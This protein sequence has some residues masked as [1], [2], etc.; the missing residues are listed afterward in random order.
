MAIHEAMEQQTISITKAGIQATL[1][2]RTAILAAANPIKGRY[3][4]SRTLKQNVE[5][6]PPIMSRFDLFF[7]VLDQCVDYLDF[8]IAQHIVHVHQKKP[9]ALK[10]EFSTD[11][12]KTYIRFARTLRPKITRESRDL[13]VQYFIELRANDTGG[14]QNSAYRITVRQ[15]E[16]MIRLAEARARLHLS[17]EVE[18]DHVREA[19]RLLKQSII[20]VDSQLALDDDEDPLPDDHD[21]HDNGQPP[22]DDGDDHNGGGVPAPGA[23]PGA[24]AGPD[25]ATKAPATKISFEEYQRLT[26]LFVWKLRRD[27]SLTGAPGLR[28][29]E[30]L[31]W[32]VRQQEDEMEISV[33]M[34][35]S[36]SK[37]GI[38]ILRRLLEVD[39]VLMVLVPADTEMARVLGV[40]PN[41]TLEDSSLRNL[42]INPPII[43]SI[44]FVKIRTR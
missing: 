18:P 24:G 10:A 36:V 2:A 21:G 28:Q 13:L 20:R 8:H 44:I 19:Y 25:A 39:R 38:K 40:H 31:A 23:G 29:D 16:S 22:S 27:E 12:L 14:G 3:D 34:S 37:K 32:W 4:E 15:L 7:V 30:L 6:S 1:N 26:N 9:E 43:F 5:I 41:Y 11:E 17:E 42:V 33:E 35:R